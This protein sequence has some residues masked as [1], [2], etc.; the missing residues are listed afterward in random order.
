MDKKILL[1]GYEPFLEFEKNPC[2]EACRNLETRNYNNFQVVVEE[3][4]MRYNQIK[5]LIQDLIDQHNPSVVICTG[6]SSKAPDICLERVAVNIGS[7]DQ[8][9]NFG[10]ESLDQ[11]LNPEGPA[12]YFSTLPIRDIVRAI[13]DNGIPARISYSAGTQGCNLVFY[14]LMD[15]LAKKGLKIP[16]G[17]IHLPRLPENAIGTNNPSMSLETS[18]RA[19]EIAVSLVASRI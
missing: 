7:A 18:T 5:E 2:I 11:I 15:Y 16:A 1:T 8:G 3:L 6:V 14:H 19:L 9:P 13:N 12:A 4:P 10:F 17:F